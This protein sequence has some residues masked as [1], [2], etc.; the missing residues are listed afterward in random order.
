MPDEHSIFRETLRER[1][2]DFRKLEE[3]H[4]RL[5]QELNG[6]VRHKTLTPQEELHKKQVQVEKLHTK[7]R[8]EAKVRDYVKQRT[9][10]S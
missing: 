3:E 2:P 8:I 4:Q 10:V 5:E 1:D 6:L 7:D 9:A